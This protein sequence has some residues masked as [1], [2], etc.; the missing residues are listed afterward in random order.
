MIDPSY[1]NIYRKQTSSLKSV[2]YINDAQ[3][4]MIYINSENNSYKP[5]QISTDSSFTQIYTKEIEEQIAHKFVNDSK[6][7]TTYS[8][9]IQI[10]GISYEAPPI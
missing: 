10:I 6:I 5:P 9:F 8:N 4:L 7:L 3:R 2:D 1:V